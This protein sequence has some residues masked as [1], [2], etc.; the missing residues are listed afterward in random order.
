MVQTYVEEMYGC[1]SQRCERL[2]INDFRISRGRSKKYCGE[3]ITHDM[4]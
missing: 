1:P 3:V 2:V 4:S